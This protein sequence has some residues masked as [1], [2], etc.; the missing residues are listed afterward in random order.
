MALSNISQMIES[1]HYRERG[2]ER[3]RGRNGRNPSVGPSR[4]YMS[5]RQRNCTRKCTVRTGRVELQSDEQEVADAGSCFP[6]L[7]NPVGSEAT[8]DSCRT[9][10]VRSI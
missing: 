7:Q 5:I 9:S 8:C 6:T 4:K 1:F 3:P 2:R 10:V